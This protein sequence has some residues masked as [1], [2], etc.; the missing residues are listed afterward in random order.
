M[1]KRTFWLEKARDIQLIRQTGSEL[2]IKGYETP[3]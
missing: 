2:N 3:I 1:S